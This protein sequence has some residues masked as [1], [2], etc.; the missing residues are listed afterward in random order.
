ME[1]QRKNKEKEYQKERQKTW[2]SVKLRRKTI[3][4]LKILEGELS[5]H[6][7]DDVIR[8]LIKQVKH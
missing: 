5:L 4:Q 2:S 3:D 1:K 7:F 8:F 6:V